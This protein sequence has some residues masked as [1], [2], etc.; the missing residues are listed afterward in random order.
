M[1][2]YANEKAASKVIAAAFF[3]LFYMRA[4]HV[5]V[6]NTDPPVI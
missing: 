3:I 5:P 4:K 2:Q 6:L 1:G